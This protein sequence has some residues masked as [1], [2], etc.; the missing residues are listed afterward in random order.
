MDTWEA[1]KM[2]GKKGCFFWKKKRRVKDGYWKERKRGFW[3]VF[4]AWEKDGDFFKKGYETFWDGEG[5]KRERKKKKEREKE[6]NEEEKKGEVWRRGKLT[7][8]GILEKYTS[9]YINLEVSYS[10]WK[11]LLFP[12]IHLFTIIDIFLYDW[13]GH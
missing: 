12:T 1:G 9:V 2:H 6:R 11:S 10:V 4:S 13:G 8:F 3:G 5:L 7:S